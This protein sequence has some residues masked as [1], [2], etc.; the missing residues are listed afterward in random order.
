MTHR[1]SSYYPRRATL[2]SPFLL[3][4]E[5]CSRWATR[6]VFRIPDTVTFLGLL[7]GWLVPGWA[8]YLRNANRSGLSTLGV[9]A[10]LLLTFF[11]FLGQAA[12]NAA[13][14][15]LLCIHCV[16]LV[17]YCKPLLAEFQWP[18]R[19]LSSLLLC[20]MVIGLV[21]LPAQQFLSNHLFIP[22]RLHGHVVVVHR[23]KSPGEIHRGEWIAF[24]VSAAS[25]YFNYGYAHG[26]VVIRD[27]VNL[28]PV[29]ALPGDEVKFDP[30]SYY[31]NGEQHPRQST[32]P[33]GGGF[34]V[35][36]HC[37]FAW[38]EFGME[39]HGTVPAANITDP[40]LQIANVTPDRFVGKVFKHWFF[41]RQ[42]VP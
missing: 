24:N 41:R 34:V 19:V 35:A 29:L 31:V 26:S 13:F 22:M 40:L 28:A 5:V 15:L 42:S 7:G 27:G 4:F 12:G 37:W 17:A 23:M 39:G 21:Y 6:Y 30:H 1:D 38:P 11:V 10:F 33:T 32:M 3:R 36:E 18:N 2:F 8:V 14:T 16:G 25:D 20:A 9:C